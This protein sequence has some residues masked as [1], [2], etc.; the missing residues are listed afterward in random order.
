MGRPQVAHECLEIN[1]LYVA[2]LCF[3]GVPIIFSKRSTI[4]K[5]RR[6]SLGGEVQEVEHLPGSKFKPQYCQKRKK[7]QKE[8]RTDDL[9]R[10]VI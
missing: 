5:A 9:Y 7:K 1:R 8:R 4:Q 3:S 6:R 2:C 10:F